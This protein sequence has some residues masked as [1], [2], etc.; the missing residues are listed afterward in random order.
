MQMNR[1]IP[2]SA[3]LDLQSKVEMEV[4]SADSKAPTLITTVTSVE[5]VLTSE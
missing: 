4:R 2:L 3:K 5:M 1:L